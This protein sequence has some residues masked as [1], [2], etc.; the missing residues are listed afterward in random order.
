[1][2]SGFQDASSRAHLYRQ[3]ARSRHIFDLRTPEQ[4]RKFSHVKR[5]MER[6]AGDMKF[7]FALSENVDAPRAVTQ[8][9]GIEVDPMEVLPLWHGDYLKYRF[10]AES[11]PWPPAMMWDEYMGEMLRYRDILREQGEMSMINPRFHAWRDRQIRR[12]AD[13]LGG[14]AHSI[15]HPV[16]AFELSDG[17]TVGCWF[18]GLSADRFQGYY[19]YSKEHAELWRGVVGVASEVFGSAAGTGFCYWAT[20]PMDNPHYDRFLLDYYQITGALPQT[21]TAAP[22]KDEAL[23]RRVLGLFNLYGTTPNRFSVL[24]TKHLDQIHMAFSPEELVGVELI[25]Q[26]KGGPTAKAFTGRARKEKLTV[27]LPEGYPTTIACVSGFLVNMPQ[28]RIQ[29]VTPVPGSE[30]WP[31]GY[32]IVAQRL[33][34][35]RDEFREGVQ[36][37]MDQHMLDSPAP[38]LPIRFRRDLQYEAGNGYFVLRSRSSEH[39]VLDDVAPISVGDLIARGNCT[40]SELVMRVTTDGTRMLAVADLLD[41]LYAAGVIEE[42]LDDRF[43]WQTSDG[44]EGHIEAV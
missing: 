41:Q 7:R 36:S 22:L 37:I 14:S 31:L 32:R 12:C 13:E 40:A 8:R 5:F 9:Y 10:K 42:D 24:S 30:R 34:R 17:C 26:G 29:L 3:G 28:G 18:C 1:M 44:M 25:L 39:R 21:T 33:F 23:T 2:R 43:A 20:D 35:T 6:L 19:D 4:R 27:A 11:A 15:T 16:I 38:H